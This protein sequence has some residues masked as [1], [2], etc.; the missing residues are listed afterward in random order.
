MSEQTG[1]EWCDHTFNIAWGCMKVSPGC[2]HCYADSSSRRWGFAVFG[3]AKTTPRR[4]F[5]AKHWN[6]PLRWNDRAQLAGVRR[7]VFCSSMCDVFEDHPT[8]DAER[9]KLWPLIRATPA[10]DWLLLTKRPERIAVRL[11]SD[12]G[13]GYPNVWLG[14]SVESQ[15]FAWRAYELAEIPAAVRF[16]SVEPMLSPLNLRDLL[17]DHGCGG[18]APHANCVVCAPALHWVIAGSESGAGAR[19]LALDWLRDLHDQCAD[20][21]VPFFL[22]QLGGHPDKRGGDKAVLDGVRHVAWPTRVAVR[23]A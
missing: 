2:K 18:G 10:L 9:E 6:D 7:R 19:P 14:T 4:T 11:P 21:G 1:I 5:G 23:S 22:K 8:I 16:L 17:P 15:G 3:P 12:W 13:D 20:A